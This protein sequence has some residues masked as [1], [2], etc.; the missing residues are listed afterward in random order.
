MA[1]RLEADELKPKRRAGAEAVHGTVK[2]YCR[3]AIFV[4]VHDVLHVGDVFAFGG[5]FVM[6]DDIVSFR[7][8]CFFIKREPWGGGL[9]FGQDY[10]HLDIRAALDAISK[11]RGLSRIIMA[12]TTKNK[13][14]TKRWLGG[15]YG[16]Q[17]YEKASEMMAHEGRSM[18]GF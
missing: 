12:A 7:P 10:V 2:I 5:A 6:D 15:G 14:C 18:T 13:E 4:S 16:T 3:D 9:V 17:S 8:I 11:D 1:A